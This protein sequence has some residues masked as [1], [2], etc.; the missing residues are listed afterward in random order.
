MNSVSGAIHLGREV[1]DE[2]RIGEVIADQAVDRLGSQLG[3][4][5]RDP[6]QDGEHVAAQV[7]GVGNLS[8]EHGPV[9]KGC[10]D[11]L[12]PGRPPAGKHRPAGPGPLSDSFHGQPGIARLPYLVPGGP[13]VAWQHAAERRLEH[14]GAA[15]AGPDA[16]PHASKSLPPAHLRRHDH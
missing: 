2:G 4:P 12:E 6:A 10:G 9:A 13:G 11:Q 8:R 5:G 16:L 7:S 14:R 1:G 15:D 3:E